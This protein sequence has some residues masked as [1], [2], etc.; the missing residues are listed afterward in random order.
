MTHFE[1]FK[2]DFS[3]W[4]DRLLENWAREKGVSKPPLHIVPEEKL[5]PWEVGF[6]Y[7]LPRWRHSGILGS[8][9]ICPERYLRDLYDGAIRRDKMKELWNILEWKLG[10]EMG[11]YLQY[12]KTYRVTL[13]RSPLVRET[14]RKAEIRA[15]LRAFRLVGKT[16]QQHTRDFLSVTGF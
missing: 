13:P 3:S 4:A 1:M 6:V 14:L 15:S 5:D 7:V 9:I 11:H 16:K 10:H 8:A 12:V 2:A